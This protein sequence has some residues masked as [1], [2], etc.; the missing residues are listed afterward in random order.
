[1]RS[2]SSASRAR[3]PLALVWYWR[4]GE[5]GRARRAPTRTSQPKDQRRL[6]QKA[7]QKISLRHG[8]GDRRGAAGSPEYRRGCR[9]PFRSRSSAAAHG[10][11]SGDIGISAR[12][13][14]T[15]S[16]PCRARWAEATT[17]LLIHKRVVVQRLNRHGARPSRERRAMALV[18]GLRRRSVGGG[19]APDHQVQRL[20]PAQPIHACCGRGRSD[21]PTARQIPRPRI[22]ADLMMRRAGLRPSH[23]LNIEGKGRAAQQ[24]FPRSGR[25]GVLQPAPD[26]LMA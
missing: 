3:Q 11:Q 2:A 13:R 17:R 23:P 25:L 4:I 21:A 20:R 10:R 12:S 1:M 19:S 6:H 24:T 26:A 14:Q 22:T 7:A 15:R 18:P 16:R 5:P 8:R 9:P